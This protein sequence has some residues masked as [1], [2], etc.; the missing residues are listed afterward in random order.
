MKPYYNVVHKIFWAAILRKLR[1]FFQD[2]SD[3]TEYENVLI[4]I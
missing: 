4:Y 3:S 2:V 1:Q